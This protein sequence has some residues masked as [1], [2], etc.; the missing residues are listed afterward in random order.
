MVLPPGLEERL[1]T[2]CGRYGGEGKSR[3]YARTRGALGKR[4]MVLF[5]ALCPAS[6]CCAHRTLGKCVCPPNTNETAQRWDMCVCAL[7][8][9]GAVTLESC[10]TGHGEGAHNP[11]SSPSRGQSSVHDLAAASP[12][13]NPLA[14]RSYNSWTGKKESTASELTAFRA[15]L[16]YRKAPL[17]FP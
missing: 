9:G 6:D 10:S 13:V 7:G 11:P 8:S 5:A 16:F 14:P 4:R 15:E 3:G 2:G 1:P 17:I 12:H